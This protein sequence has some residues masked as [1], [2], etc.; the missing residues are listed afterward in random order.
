FNVFRMAR[1]LLG[2]GPRNDLESADPDQLGQDHVLHAA[3]EI[4]VVLV[5]AETLK[6]KHGD[7][8][9]IDHRRLRKMRC[10]WSPTQQ[11]ER[12]N[13]HEQTHDCGEESPLETTRPGRWQGY[14]RTCCRY[15]R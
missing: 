9:E 13:D 6:G 12:R 15:G 8:L 2:R 10:D 14:F 1:V 4:G 11:R 3:R 7:R 5:R